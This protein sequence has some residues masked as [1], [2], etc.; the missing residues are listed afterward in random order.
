MPSKVPYIHDSLHFQDQLFFA[1]TETWLNE[2]YDAEISISN[3]TP[4]R[5]DRKRNKKKRFGRN[6]GGALIYVRNDIANT[7]EP[8]LTYSN[9]AVDIIA[10][11]SSTE[12]L[13]LAC[14]YRQPDNQI[15]RSISKEFRQAMKQLNDALSNHQQQNIIIMGD[16]NLPNINW[17]QHDSSDVTG[18]EKLMYQTLQQL[19]EDHF[20]NQNIREAT[21]VDGNTLDL[22]LTNNED[23]IHNLEIQI[24]PR[25]TSDHYIINVLSKLSTNRSMEDS[26]EDTIP[27]VPLRTLNFHHDNINWEATIADFDNIN[28]DE[29]LA[30]LSPSDSV[31]KIIN[32]CFNTSEKHVPKSTTRTHAKRNTVPRDR[33]NLMAKR[34]RLQKRHKRSTSTITRDK[35]WKELVQIE[36]SLHKS[37][38]SSKQHAE[39]RAINAIKRN[40]KYF[41]TYAK[42]FSKTSTRIGPLKDKQNNWIH[43]S[44]EIAELLSNQF[45]SVFSIPDT[46]CPTK[47][48]LFNSEADLCD[49]DFTASDFIA[50]INELSATAGSGPDGLPSILIKKCKNS[51]ARCLL[52][53]WQKCYDL[54][55]TPQAHK[56]TQI[57]PKFKDG[58]KSIPVNFRPIA[59]TSHLIKL[60]EKVVRTKISSYLETQ[61]LYNDNQHGFRKG[62]SC[63]S[64]LLN[65]FDQINEQLEK[66]MGVDT[67]YLD[68]SKAFDR[69]DTETLLRKLSSLGIGGKLGRWIHS[70]LT[71]RTQEVIVNKTK[72][73]K[74]EVKSGVPQG[75]VLGPL[76]F[77][78][79]I[80]D[81]DN[82]VL[83]SKV[84]CFADDSRA[85]RGISNPSDTTKLQ[86][87][88]NSI[89]AWANSNRMQFNN[90]KFEVIRYRHRNS[91]SEPHTYTTQAGEPI[92][93]KEHVRDLGIIMSNDCSF[94]R[95]IQKV[96]KTV[97]NLAAWILR[98]FTTRDNTT[99]LTTWKTLVLPRHDY[100]CILW[101]PYL[102]GQINELE[103]IQ[104]SFLRK[105][106][107]TNTNYWEALKK[108]HLYSLQRRRERYTMIYAYK[109]I[110]N[111]VP[112]T[113]LI[114]NP[115]ERLGLLLKITTTR[116]TNTP[117][118]NAFN[119]AAPRLWNTLPSSVRDLP[120]TSVDSFKRQLDRH[121]KSIPDEPQIP[122]M[123]PRCVRTSNS[124]LHMSPHVSPQSATTEDARSR[125]GAPLSTL[126]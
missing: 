25:S 121:L 50:A 3:Y 16:F 97:R 114:L 10:I 87:D 40:S 110:H 53:L 116:H 79:M 93:E 46:P 80:S 7:F 66:G 43:K 126:S 108:H 41:Y 96:T 8:T 31:S 99:M 125:A 123:K 112:Q 109:I 63:L 70:F 52:A 92:T 113:G 6:G 100:C 62:R 78:I 5:A 77:V 45:K 89:Y 64:Q 76:L 30:N 85:Y 122:S 71:N 19:C 101:S 102:A 118:Y 34:C 32:I 88:L 14:V 81:I 54:E 21:H 84:L 107:N 69:V 9:G 13:H 48:T 120:F 94:K 83:H 44:S 18:E 2:E 27:L 24:P 15:Q 49:I 75:S 56:D 1:L 124:L 95:H 17:L 38:Q 47:E 104:W 42:K 37:R 22:L 55:M 90:D 91:I 119:M 105:C 72:S 98:T 115:S 12:N 67:I 60:F 28:W 20:L 29:E 73:N 111:Q 82:N 11:Y 33:K 23:I 57:I 36:K 65:Y 51:F 61:G 68:F 86:T 35:I 59:L 4:F 106:K 26:D 58:L 117:R 103:S 74:A 39:N